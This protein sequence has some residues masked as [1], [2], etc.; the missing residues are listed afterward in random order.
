MNQLPDKIKSIVFDGKRK[1]I[2]N[3]ESLNWLSR[4][5]YYGLKAWIET[6]FQNNR[7]LTVTKLQS[8]FFKFMKWNSL[9]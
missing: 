2:C 3:K 8:S 5:T 4:V 9:Q 6:I 7:H 1:N